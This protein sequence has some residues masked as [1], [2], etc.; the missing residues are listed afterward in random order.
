[1]NY[2]IY[3]KKMKIKAINFNF[4]KY[5]I[6]TLIL[7]IGI[8]FY[9]DSGFNIDE[10]FH[11]KNGFY[12]LSYISEFLN[13]ESL[14]LIAD[15]KLE[16]ITGFTLSP[17]EYYNKYSIIFDV[18]AAFFEVILNTNNPLNYYRLRHLLIFIYY[19]FGLIFLYKILINRF[20]N[21]NLAIFGVIFLFLTPRI[22]GDSFQNNKDIIFLVFVIISYYFFFK[23]I[24]NLNIKNLVFFSLYAAI[25]TTMRMFGVIFPFFFLFF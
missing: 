3:N 15:K 20:R 8:Y 7:S 12:W 4:N 18:P 22:F 5:I 1:M 9:Q 16:S 25:A 11:R 21:N 23:I 14:K 17:I 2:Q 10:K 6:F 19:F 13:I 24:D